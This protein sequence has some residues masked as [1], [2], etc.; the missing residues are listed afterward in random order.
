MEPAGATV[1][2]LSM[3]IPMAACGS[4]RR[5]GYGDGSPVNY[6]AAAILARRTLTQ[7]D[8]GSGLSK[9]GFCRNLPRLCLICGISESGPKALSRSLLPT[10]LP[11]LSR[12]LQLPVPLGVDLLLTPGDH[13]LRRDV[14]NR[15]VQTDVVV[16]LDVALH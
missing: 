13:V 7:G 5:T 10:N 16:M 4:E 1:T 11:L 3:K 6:L 2:F 15:A 14:A 12:R 8:H 9:C